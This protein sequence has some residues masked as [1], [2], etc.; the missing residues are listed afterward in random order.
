MSRPDFVILSGAFASSG[1][2]A[3]FGRLP[4]AML[5]IGNA[6]LYEHQIDFALRAADTDPQITLSLPVNYELDTFDR[7]KLAS[8]GVNVVKVDPALTLSQS[9]ACVL[10][11]INARGP[12]QLLH[13]DTLLSGADFGQP[14]SFAVKRTADYYNWGEVIEEA[15][16]F[17]LRTSFGDGV[18]RRRVLCGYFNLSD[19]NTLRSVLEPDVT[20][21]GALN[22]YKAKKPTKLLEA[23]RWFDFGHVN[24]YY[25]ARRDLL[26]TRAHNSI[27]CE[28]NRLIK[29]SENRAKMIAEAHWYQTVPASLRTYLPNYLGSR[30]VTHRD[31]LRREYD[32]EYL[33]LPNLADLAVYGALPV[34][35]WRMICNKCLDCLTK[36]DAIEPGPDNSEGT[37]DFREA[38]FDFLVR[39]KTL[40]RLKMFKAASSFDGE[41]PLFLNGNAL[42]C[43]DDM[44][45][46]LIS[47]IRP[48]GTQDVRMWH[49]DFF[50]GNILYDGRSRGI[51][52]VDPR[53]ESLDGVAGIFG[54]KRYDRAKLLHSLVGQYDHIIANRARFSQPTE[55]VFELTFPPACFGSET[56]AVI[57]GMT[58]GTEPLMTAETLAL[59]ALLFFSMLPLHAEDPHRQL[60]MLA[61]GARLYQLSQNFG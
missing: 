26:V 17:R 27:R 3:E 47:Q 9:L 1:L 50:F 52:L 5:P 10:E 45:T 22:A 55:G 21:L 43:L 29:S 25:Q 30:D 46:Q 60:V 35:Q 57:A 13:G 59:T 39:R 14:D 38:H 53:G 42:P 49:G 15:D 23:D 51:K 11:A 36:F 18:R 33:F 32:L 44:V 48:T 54:D 20:F 6:K 31:V 24:L 61:N 58:V 40:S 12:L 56:A 16:G 2:I 19:A 37:P 28:E 8:L 34:Y 4:P 7:D 41:R